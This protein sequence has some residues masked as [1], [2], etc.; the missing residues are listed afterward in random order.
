MQIE[1]GEEIWPL[2]HIFRISR[3]ASMEVHV[4]VATVRDGDVTGRGEGVPIKR[5]DQSCASVIAQI[6]SIKHERN[7]DRDRLRELLPAGAGRN[8]LDC[9][10]W[11]LEAKRS[12][13]RAWELANIPLIDSVQTSF[14]I[15]LDT[16]NRME[17]SAADFME[18]IEREANAKEGRSPD[19][20]RQRGGHHSL[21]LKLGGDDADL[22]RVEAVRAAAPGARLIVDA[23][24]SWS[25]A[26]YEEIVPALAK[27]GVEF[28][29]QPF[30]ADIDEALETLDHL[31]PI[32]ADESCHTSL[33]IPRLKNRYEMINVKLDKTGG[34]TEALCLC[35][36][37]REAGFSLLIGSMVCT[38]LGVAPARLLA[39]WGDYADLDGPMLLAADRPHGLSYQDGNIGIPSPELWG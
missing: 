11:D 35:V 9:A 8:A 6:E 22:T 15:S 2:K 3:G 5:Y 25:P 4:V 23:N 14:T 10:L 31:V 32:C 7:L 26:H 33:D 1:A 21:K 27:L 34:L 17:A 19:R 36:R 29:E 16:P 39:S 12:G 18:Q 30:R 38:S 13:K 20:P 28:I 24:E 37:A